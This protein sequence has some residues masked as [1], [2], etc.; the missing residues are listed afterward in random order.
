MLK[1]MVSGITLTLLLIGTLTLAFN[2]QPAKAASETIIDT[3]GDSRFTKYP[4][5]PYWWSVADHDVFH[6]RAYNNNFWYTYCGAPGQGD[7]YFG[8]WS[9]SISG[10]YDVFV[11]IPNPDPFG[12]YTP[13]HSANYQVYHQGGLTEKT[14]NQALRLG[15]WYS[16]GRFTFGAS[17]LIIL[18]DRTGEPYLSTMVAF[19]AIKFVPTSPI[20]QL[21]TLNNGYV[22]PSS[23]DTSTT[24]SYYVTYSDPEG[25]VPTL[26]Y[27]YIDYSPHTMAKISGDYVSGAVFRYSTTLSV[28]LDHNYY[29]YFEDSVHG[30]TKSLPPSGT[31]PGPSV[32]PPPQFDFTVE[33]SPSSGSVQQGG[34]VS[35]TVTVTLTSGSTQTVTLTTS[36]LPSGAYATFNPSSGYPTFTS[37]FAISTSTTTPT[38]TFYITIVGSGGGLTRTATYALTVIPL[39]VPEFSITASPTSLTIQ[40]GSSGSSTITITSINGFNQPVQLSVSGAPSGVTATMSPSQVTPPA[41]GTA[42]ST[43]TVSVATTATPGSY[44]LTVTGTNGTLT[45]STNLTLKIT[46]PFSPPSITDVTAFYTLDSFFLGDMNGLVPLNQYFVKGHNIERVEFSIYINAAEQVYTDTSPNG[47]GWY[48]SEEYDMADVTSNL[49]I[50]AYNEAEVWVQETVETNVFETPFWLREVITLA[51]ENENIEITTDPGSGFGNVWRLSATFQWPEDPFEG[52]VDLSSLPLIGGKYGVSAGFGFGLSLA[53]DKTVTAE[54]SGKFKVTIADHE[55]GADIEAKAT[56]KIGDSIELEDFV[57]NIHGNIKIPIKQKYKWDVWRWSIGVEVGID[58]EADASFSFHIEEATS[59]GTFCD[60]FDW[61]RTAN[62][63]RFT[64]HPYAAA[65]VGIGELRVEGEGTVTLTVHVPEPYFT[66]PDDLKVE[67]TIKLILKT[68]LHSWE[69]TVLKYS[70]D[71]PVEWTVNASG[72]GWINRT[73]ATG[74]YAQYVWMENTTAGNYLEN[75]Y[76]YANP[77]VASSSE[78][79]MMVWTHDDL[80]KPYIQGYEVYYSLWNSETEVW[81]LPSPVTNNTIPEDAVSVK[82]DAWGNAVAVW[83]QINNSSLS[84]SVDPFSLFNQTELAYAVWNH[85]TGLWSEP[86]LITNNYAYDYSP[87]LISD[88][89]GN[90][91]LTWLV[92]QD[93]NF[94]T[95]NDLYIYSSTWNGEQ[96]SSP[97]FVANPGLISSPIQA[98]YHNGEAVVVWSEH[99]DGNTT[100]LDDTELFYCQFSN[101]SWSSPIQLTE[102]NLEDAEPSIGF[103]YNHPVFAWIQRNETNSLIFFDPENGSP[104]SVL[105]RAGVSS[106]LLS[107]DKQNRTLIVWADPA[108]QTPFS[109]SLTPDGYITFVELL[110]QSSQRNIYCKTC[111][112]QNVIM[113][114]SNDNPI[115]VIDLDAQLS[116]SNVTSLKTVVNEGRCDQINITI[117]NQGYFTHPINVTLYANAT[118]ICG[119]SATLQGD[120]STTLTFTWNTTGFEKGNYTIS[121]YAWPVP[122]ETDTTDNTYIN[123]IVKIV[124]PGDVNG[125][126]IV[127]IFDL[128]LVASAYGSTPADPNWNPNADINGDNVVDIFDLVLVASHYGETDP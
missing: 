12:G 10:E 86:V 55:A 42:T 64:V 87:L 103:R 101:Y 100:T 44:T 124:I 4:S 122:G 34:S 79:V 2:I 89:D 25:D 75:V 66:Y 37:T 20:N 110:E 41:G 45:H 26:K 23:G 77:S 106:P 93:C 40:Q 114:M 21:F 13:T 119:C 99:T 107:V 67:A 48:S 59:D 30:H 54:G 72:R 90:L 91:M 92:D 125:D 51:L 78:T 95:F 33:V 52:E 36:G 70:S 29:F 104:R 5:G 117:N 123:G 57:I 73:W 22:S 108:Y 9:A 14:V 15:G 94:S 43:L 102:N 126:C 63:I 88:Q 39:L 53:S 97:L 3:H 116:V 16:L 82:F 85:T 83:N 111:Q 76:L 17:A 120:S 98:A 8:T 19:D 7:L 46:I 74:D 105:E 84:E 28:G 128:V 96:W 1:R 35:V 50:T 27:V 31:Y 62:D 38:G 118:A 11:W 61:V 68:F 6:T 56:I 58:F 24:F 18:N 47:E 109:F 69:W 32:P 80:S 112:Y 60:G 121:A 71:S 81:S 127:D 49:T 115:R 65:G 113:D